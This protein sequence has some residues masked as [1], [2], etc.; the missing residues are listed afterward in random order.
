MLGKL[1]GFNWKTSQE[2]LNILT[3]NAEVHVFDN[4]AHD[5]GPR[6]EGKPVVTKL[7]QDFLA[8]LDNNDSNLMQQY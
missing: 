4:W 6:S 7:V 1:D 3:T 2:D 8:R 5:F